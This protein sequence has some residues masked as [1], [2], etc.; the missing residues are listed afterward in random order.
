MII[1]SVV[2]L[3]EPFGPDEPVDGSGGHRERQ[4][5]DGRRAVEALGDVRQWDGIG[6]V[7]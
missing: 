4:V 7:N 6:H 1:R 3:P 5:V 2:V